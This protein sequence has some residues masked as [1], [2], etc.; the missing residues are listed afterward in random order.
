MTL[1]VFLLF[2]APLV[3]FHELGHLLLAKFFKVRVEKFSIGMGPQLASFHWRGTE[4]VFSLLPIGGFIK[5][6]GEDLL[7]RDEVPEDQKKFAYNHKSPFQRFWIVLAGP[8]ANFLL[9]FVLFLFL[10]IKGQQVQES[11]IFSIK[12]E[13]QLLELGLLSGDKILAANGSSISSFEEILYL[14]QDSIEEFSVLRN[15]KEISL[16]VSI[17]KNT[18]FSLI[19]SDIQPG[20]KPIVFDKYGKKKELQNIFFLDD[21]IENK[22]F[23][24]E[25]QEFFCSK[26]FWTCL[27][28]KEFYPSDLK[29]KNIIIGKEADQLGL[30]AQDQIIKIDQTYIFSIDQLKE[31]LQIEKPIKITVLRNQEEK[32]FETTLKEKFLGIETEI[33]LVQEKQVSIVAKN[34]KEAFRW[35]S[36]LVVKI[37]QGIVKAF[38]ELIFKNFNFD[39]LGGP[40]SIGK[41]ANETFQS[42]YSLFLRFMAIFSINL[43]IMNLFPIPV[44]DGGHILILLI[45]AV[46]RRPIPKNI[47]KIVYMMGFF[48][49]IFLMGYGLFNDALR[50]FGIKKL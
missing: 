3:F 35:S 23:S 16:K 39:Q 37:S 9:A 50:F 46:V 43:A 42:S 34:L 44:L 14:P 22:N 20:K 41:M 5:M 7:S 27:L 30:K 32:I 11:Q 38:Y 12:K 19:K 49:L 18:F 2:F 24:I 13:S 6:Y 4:Y 25:N 26:D 15:Q 45:E 48:T 40:V 36:I 1:L 33:E 8:L 21:S 17:K 10:A 29:I 31:K 28:E 47:I